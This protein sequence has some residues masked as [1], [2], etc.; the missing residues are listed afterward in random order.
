MITAGS[1]SI[2]GSD[3]DRRGPPVEIR[4]LGPIRMSADDRDWP[5]GDVK[6]RCL[7]ALL[8]LQPNTSVA[9]DDL[10]DGLWDNK[11][12]KTARDTMR[13]YVSRARRA[14]T[15]SQFMAKLKT[16]NGGYRF[17]LNPQ[18][19]DYHR[20][21][22]L[23]EQAHKAAAGGDHPTAARRFG[24]AVGLWTGRPLG[25]LGTEHGRMLRETMVD[26]ELLPAYGGLFEAK[27]H[28]RDHEFVLRHL[29]AQL[30]DHGHD[31][32][33]AGLWMRALHAGGRGREITAFHR[34]F[35]Q[36]VLRRDDAPPTAEFERLYRT[37]TS[38]EP[39]AEVT[40]TTTRL[41]PRPH[42]TGREALLRELDEAMS[43]DSALVA[44]DGPAGVG[45]T[46]LLVN[47]AR[48]RREPV[49]YANLQGFWSSAPTEPAVAF[50][51]FL[52]ELG[53][54]ND[55][56]PP[57]LSTRT[58]LLRETALQVGATFV[59]D[60]VRD[61]RHA[62]ALLA[63][64]GDRPTVV[65]SRYA[66]TGL[67]IQDA[68]RR[69]TVPP[70]PPAD[71]FLLL[72]KLLGRRVETEPAG[73]AE[74]VR[75]TA[76]LPL[77]LC[78]VGEHA[79]TRP[80]VPLRALAAELGD[81]FRILDAGGHGDKAALTLR[82]AFSW[83]FSALT[84]HA[85]ELFTLLGLHPRP[86]FS[87]SAAAAICG[88]DHAAT[89]DCLDQLIGAHLVQQEQADRYSVHD[90]LHAFARDQVITTAPPEPQ[91][92]AER[93]MLD[94]YLAS[95]T[96]ARRLLAA[97]G[98]DVPPLP[99]AEAIEPA[100]F[101]TAD[102]ALDWG[103]AER[104]NLVEITRYA[105]RLNHNDHLWR[106]APCVLEVLDSHGDITEAIEV[107]ELGLVAAT[108]AGVP[109][110]QAGCLNNLG[111][112]HFKRA[113]YARAVPYFTRA[114]ELFAALGNEYG[115]AIAMHNL[116][117][118]ELATGNPSAAIGW[119]DKSLVLLPGLD[120]GWA[121]STVHHRKGN[122]HRA[123]G[124]H[125]EAR[126]QYD[127]AIALRS[128]IPHPAGEAAVISSQA[129]LHLERDELAAATERARA[130]LRIQR[131]TKDRTG[132]ADTLCVL[133]RVFLRAGDPSA[134]GCAV[135]AATGYADLRNLRGRAAALDLAGQAHEAVGEHGLAASAWRAAADGFEAVGESTR[136]QLLQ[137]C[138]RAAAQH[139]S[140]PI[141]APRSAAR[142]GVRS[143]YDESS[144]TTPLNS[145]GML[146]NNRQQNRRT[147]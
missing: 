29:P 9:F 123:L 98:H 27:L 101:T 80:S 94:W 43:Q 53:V 50:A 61:D 99:T 128:A 37:L 108:A 120:N 49:L 103:S 72:R 141:P 7:V 109:E 115:L 104:A 45:K 42:F 12:P 138:A 24:E 145:R 77:A 58:A 6:T 19:I 69:F 66:L 127:L 136:S 46:A 15:A 112:A 106:L 117:T 92:R 64:T 126:A 114:L 121:P 18:L 110:G 41:R 131:S 116:G 89:R 129:E 90:L 28:L 52:R 44:V 95:A 56:V 147:F 78:I 100:R 87:G 107:N 88:R 76:G 13:S 2:V 86:R 134:V 102:A 38:G 142:A 105:G 91:A 23:T 55:Q 74:F 51:D 68:A 1:H 82:S 26:T 33:L 119:F 137:A 8:S 83:S 63:A 14:L 84:D 122:A 70:L 124:E 10:A 118:I 97:D 17:E 113:E 71:A 34:A 31:E 32:A 11:W 16:V 20:F 36:R 39:V 35:T 22:R 4:I 79:A 3:S 93:R 133:A 139:D 135:E 73:A 140:S 21:L 146:D 111:F 96:N 132:Q 75:L 40:R 130:A 125:E 48:S 30:A 62:R 144:R 85:R 54:P 65:A 81:A 59:L 143:H 47:W 60:N 67:A 5:L 57:D 25:E